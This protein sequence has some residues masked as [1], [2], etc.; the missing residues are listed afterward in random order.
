MS[1]ALEDFFDVNQ[2]GDGEDDGA[3]L[4]EEEDGAESAYAGGELARPEALA[5]AHGQARGREAEKRGEQHRVHVALLAREAH[6]VTARWRGLRFQFVGLPA[7]CSSGML[8][9]IC[10]SRGE[11]LT[12]W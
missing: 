11:F 6:E 7:C 4:V 1:A 12:W 9:S 10:R 8:A 3:K 2:E 5:E